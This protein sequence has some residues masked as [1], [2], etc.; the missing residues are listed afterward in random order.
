MKDRGGEKR[1]DRSNLK[2]TLVDRITDT[3]REKKTEKDK[4]TV[5]KLREHIKQWM[6]RKYFSKKSFS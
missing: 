3:S 5:R 2:N 6:M 4:D 1:S